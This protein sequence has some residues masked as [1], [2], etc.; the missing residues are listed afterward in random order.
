MTTIITRASKGS[1]LS[2]TELDTTFTNLNTAKMEDVDTRSTIQP[3][4]SLDFTTGVLDPRIT[5][6]RA[7]TAGGYY[8][9]KSSAMAEQNLLYYSNYGGTAYLS[10]GTSSWNY[11]TVVAPDGTTTAS[12]IIPGNGTLYAAYYMTNGPTS[13]TNPTNIYTV[14]CYA[15]ANGFQYL[16][17]GTD[18]TSAAVEADLINGTITGGTG[19]IVAIANGWYRIIAA[20]RTYPNGT[21]YPTIRS[22]SGSYILTG[23]DGVKGINVW[24]FQSEQRSQVTAYFP[25]TTAAN[26]NWIPVIK[27]A[28]TNVPRFDYDPIAGTPSGLLIEEQRTNLMTYSSTFLTPSDASIYSAFGNFNQNATISPDGT[29]TSCL[30]INNYTGQ[31]YSRLQRG[32]MSAANNS[33]YTISI[34]AKAA[35]TAQTVTANNRYFGIQVYDGTV[36]LTTFDL[37]NGV[38]ANNY[39]GLTGSIT[40]VGNGWYRC[41]TV[42]TATLTSSPGIGFGPST[43]TTRESYANSGVYLWGAQYELGALASTYIPTPFTYTSRSSTATYLGANGYI[44]TANTNIPRYQISSIGTPQLLVES[45]SSNLLDSTTDYS[46]WGNVYAKGWANISAGVGFAKNNMALAPD[47]T[48]TAAKLTFGGTNTWWGKLVPAVNGQTYSFSNWMRVADGGANMSVTFKYYPTG[49][50]SQQSSATFTVTNTWQLFTAVFPNISPGLYY[51][52]GAIACSDT[53]PIYVWGSQ[54]EN[55]SAATSYI[56]SI[57]T[58]TSRASTGTYYDASTTA[59]AEQNLFPYSLDGSTGTSGWGYLFSTFNGST[60]APNGTSNAWV[61]L[62]NSGTQYHEIG[63]NSGMATAGTFTFSS[64]LKAN[65]SNYASLTVGSGTTN[66][67]TCTA[68]LLSG[69]ISN[70]SNSGTFTYLNSSITPAANG[71]YR[72]ALSFVASILF[73]PE[74]SINST[75]TPIYGLYGL[76]NWNA[77]GTE[78]INVWGAQLEQRANVTAYTP[79]TSTAITNYIPVMQTATAN[80]ARFDY[81]PVTRISKGLVV[82]PAATNLAL[83]SG[84]VGG[85]YWSNQNIVVSGSTISPDGTNTANKLVA[86]A[87]TTTYTYR[88]DT[89]TAAQYTF[90]AYFKYCSGGYSWVKLRADTGFNYGVYFNIATG[91]VGN[92]TAGYIGTI[93]PAGNG[94]YRCSITF[95]ATAVNW[96]SVIVPTTSGGADNSLNDGYTGIFVWGAQLELGSIP[97]SYIPTASSQVTRAVDV[98]TSVTQ[99]RAADVYSSATVTRSKD[100]ALMSG[101]NYLN[102]Y[103]NNQG[104]FYVNYQLYTIVGNSW[105]FQNNIGNFDL[106][107][108]NF[109]YGVYSGTTDLVTALTSVNNIFAG[110]YST[111]NN[112]THAASFNGNTAI[113]KTNSGFNGIPTIFYIGSGN[114]GYNFINGWIKKLVYYPVALSNTQL[115]LISSS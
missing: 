52:F 83:N 2:N 55:S 100:Y 112:S 42:Y 51:Q 80:T 21:F 39:S 82:E 77:L 41:S 57:E 85:P 63:I 26:T 13:Y 65:T 81:D 89:L 33:S 50:G 32:D 22:T 110:A 25:T 69:Q 59:L 107:T 108:G 54:W 9:G 16:A 96:Y 35:N 14:S 29:Q 19:S 45:A 93:T 7:S 43:A 17:I 73:A 66:W 70:T 49:A 78:T 1:I 91:T 4:L 44:Q 113:G 87:T 58:F 20:A 46:D 30:L 37:F 40:S 36:R 90:S 95:T 111:A 74:I 115:Q 34:Y 97:T 47:G 31:Q 12:A 67:A 84:N 48:F 6:S 24:G 56:P 86:T 105:V 68:N 109:R 23:A 27:T 104:T 3:S 99:T 92:A 75:A 5:Y 28:N 71:W 88:S 72:V 62:A 60:S 102:W 103:N 94:W 106:V 38:V 11:N 64:Y 18:N 114:G 101:T 98:Y 15:K 79:T 10:A 8:D 53:R 61:V 76:E